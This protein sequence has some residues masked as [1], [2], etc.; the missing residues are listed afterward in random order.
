MTIAP[1]ETSP[2]FGGVHSHF[3]LIPMLDAIRL[4]FERFLYKIAPA[5]SL[6]AAASEE[7]SE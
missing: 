6:T 2:G 5:A 1:I 7:V 3:T 4:S